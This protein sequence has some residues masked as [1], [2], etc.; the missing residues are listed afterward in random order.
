MSI[1]AQQYAVKSGY[2][3]YKLTGN[4]TGTKKI[5][6]NNYGVNSYTKTESVSVVK[7]FG[8]T[9]E[10]REHTISV[11]KGEY[12][13]SANLEE[14]T[15]Q[16]GK[17][18][19]YKIGR[20]YAESLSETEKKQLEQQIMDA[21]NAE[22]IGTESILGNNC[23]IISVMG[24]KSWIYKGVILK[25]EANVMGIHTVET[26]IKFDENISVPVSK[27]TPYEGVEYTDIQE[28]E[29]MYYG[30]ENYSDYDDD[31]APTI[32]V[33][34]PFDKFKSTVNKCAID[35]YTNRATNSIEGQHFAMFIQGTN[36]ITIAATSKEN[37]EM[38]EIPSNLEEFNH[39]GH[40]CMFGTL[41][42]DE[43][44]ALI[45]D[46]PAHNMYIIIAASAN[47][48][49]AELLSINNQLKF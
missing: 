19:Y 17:N 4:T 29:A 34:Y 35:G 26:A 10:T 15:G 48:T 21:F 28:M 23:D 11:M 46:Y 45:I 37:A 31:D 47:K 9:N 33:K 32:P 25:S 40:K 6:W 14:S 2:V 16:K 1:N 3:E 24:A 39:N 41:D 42:E 22:K 20:D 13:W 27:F 49:K 30:D 12:F 43:G 7:I 38:N 5:W 36:S 18:P 44:T 8:I